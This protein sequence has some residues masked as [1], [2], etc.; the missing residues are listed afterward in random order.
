MSWS[1]QIAN[2]DLA[3]N[4]A[5][6]TTV[7]G[8][9]KLV[10]DLACCI[11][12]PMGNDPLHPGYGSLID[13]GIGTDGSYTSGVIGAPNDTR[14]GNFVVSEIN[15]ICTQYQ[16]Q[17]QARYKADVATYGKSTISASEALLGVESI[18]A[19]AS[20]DHLNV[21]ATLQTGSGDQPITLSVPSS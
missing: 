7:Q 15:R 2:G 1:L 19:T 16:S 18:T 10:Q 8:S 5:D 11:L 4:G 17:Q 9:Q 20:Q 12:E 6:M 13:G 14:A 3:F 21:G